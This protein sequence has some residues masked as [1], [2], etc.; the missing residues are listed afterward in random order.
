MVLSA[1]YIY[2]SQI[3]QF[4]NSQNS[5]WNWTQWN[6]YKQFDMYVILRVEIEMFWNGY[7]VYV[8]DWASE[9]H[10]HYIFSTSEICK[11]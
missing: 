1:L 2:S 11:I 10:T 7:G 8:I 6:S 5:D 9:L 3:K 4:N